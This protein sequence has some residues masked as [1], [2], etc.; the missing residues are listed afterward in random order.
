MQNIKAAVGDDE[1]FAA[2]AEALPPFR[3]RVPGDDF[4]VKVHAVILPARAASW[5]LF[6]NTTGTPSS[7][8][9]S[10]LVILC[11]TQSSFS[12][13]N[14]SSISSNER[15]NVPKCMGI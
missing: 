15:R 4:V 14:G 2:R 13:R 1:F 10:R 3:Q 12:Q 8:A 9:C 5:Q 11:C 6:Q 7:I